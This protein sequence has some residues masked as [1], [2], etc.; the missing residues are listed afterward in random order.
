[1]EKESGEVSTTL[2]KSEDSATY[3]SAI[4]WTMI[5]SLVAAAIP[6]HARAAKKLL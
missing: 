2:S 5:V 6:L 3:M 1:M 4:T